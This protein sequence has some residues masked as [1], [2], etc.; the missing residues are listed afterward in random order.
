MAG[1]QRC[2]E[3]TCAPG[4]GPLRTMPRTALTQKHKSVPSLPRCFQQ[5]SC[6]LSALPA[7]KGP[8]DPL[9]SRDFGGRG[10]KLCCGGQSTDFRGSGLGWRSLIMGGTERDVSLVLALLP[11]HLQP[12]SLFPPDFFFSFKEREKKRK[13]MYSTCFYYYFLFF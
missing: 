9:T 13:T 10:S 3:T 2:P 6:G 1:D 11:L 12:Q 8:A 7:L 4:P 5:G